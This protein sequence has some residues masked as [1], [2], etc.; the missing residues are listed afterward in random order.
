MLTSDHIDAYSALLRIRRAARRRDVVVAGGV[1]LVFILA[2]V[3][4][5][6]LSGMSGRSVYLVS[7]M[8]IAFGLA[9]VT[10]WVRLEIVR[11]LIEFADTLQRAAAHSFHEN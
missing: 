10:A 6:L 1:F 2:T 9:F 11:A 8:L 5:G 3:A 4:L 7:A